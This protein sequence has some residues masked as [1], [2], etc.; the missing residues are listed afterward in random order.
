MKSYTTYISIHI[1]GIKTLNHH[2]NPFAKQ[3]FSCELFYTHSSFCMREPQC[4]KTTRIEEN[5]KAQQ[6][7]KKYIA[8]LQASRNKIKAIIIW[9]VKFVKNGKMVVAELSEIHIPKYV[10]TQILTDD[11]HTHIQ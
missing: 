6:E 4:R 8:L 10:Y 1:H 5:I 11:W 3:F 9:T 2:I 7:K